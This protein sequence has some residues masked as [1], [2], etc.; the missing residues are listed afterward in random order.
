MANET[1][2]ERMVREERERTYPRTTGKVSR[3]DRGRLVVGMIEDALEEAATPP[4]MRRPR[5][6]A[7]ALRRGPTTLGLASGGMV[8][9]DGSTLVTLLDI[10]N[11]LLRQRVDDAVAAVE[12]GEYGTVD[13]YM[14]EHL[15]APAAAGHTAAPSGEEEAR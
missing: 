9:V 5:L 12:A 8:E 7:R 1:Q 13:E 14:F 11:S 2:V 10:V 6:V 15:A 4:A 3:R